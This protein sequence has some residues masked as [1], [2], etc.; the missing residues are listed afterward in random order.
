M[1][2]RPTPNEKSPKEEALKQLNKA[3]ADM[4]YDILRYHFLL[5][6]T[7]LEKNINSLSE[8]K[9]ITHSKDITR[10][11]SII[12]AATDLAKETTRVLGPSDKNHE[13]EEELE[14]K[15]SIDEIS[16]ALDRLFKETQLDS[17]PHEIKQA[18][19]SLIGCILTITLSIVGVIFSIIPMIF[20][21]LDKKGTP[22]WLLLGAFMGGI[23]G[24]RIP[25]KLLQ[26]KNEWALK[27]ALSYIKESAPNVQ[28]IQD[29]QA[30]KSKLKQEIIDQSF[31]RS[32]EAFETFCKSDEKITLTLKL[33]PAKFGVK[34]LKHYIGNHLWIDANIPK[35]L[36]SNIPHSE[37]ISRI[38]ALGSPDPPR[39]L[40]Q[41]FDQ[42]RSLNK[43]IH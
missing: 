14:D 35:T 6:Y 7:A 33:E 40:C 1:L 9:A 20:S 29:R 16:N 42:K 15:K 12:D 39:T 26:S 5:L 27:T 18:S 37:N 30:E 28:K 43:N 38:I 22:G 19:L 31:N 25:Q 2:N 41:L 8:K 34:H 10:L 4:P 13:G 23:L 11:T 21:C 3:I 36:E 32:E 24:Y 17:I